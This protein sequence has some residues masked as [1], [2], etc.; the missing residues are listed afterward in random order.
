[1]PVIDSSLDPRSATFAANRDAMAALVDD[2]RAK[3]AEVEQGGGDAARARH[4]ARGKLLPRERVRTLLDPG[5]PVPR[6][7]AAR[8]VR[9]VRRQHRG[10]GHHH[11]HRPGDRPR[12]RDRLQRRDGQGRHLL[13]DDGEEA[14]ARAGHRAREP[15]AV[16]LSRRFRRREPAATRTTC[17]PTAIT[18]AA[19]ST[20]RRPCRR[21][22]SRRSPWSWDR[23]PPAAPT[24]RRCPTSR[25]SS[26]SRARSSSPGR[27]W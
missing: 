24:C 14:P 13:P 15:P 16:H 22:A 11:R 20:T 8:R 1:M 19:S 7:L 10:R 6:A 2:L 18:S 26:A 5:T 3:L 21:R 23:A 27:R 4:V 9:H 12:M 17:S 25:S